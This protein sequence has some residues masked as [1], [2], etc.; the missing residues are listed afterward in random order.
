MA[1]ITRAP[2]H[3]DTPVAQA[4]LESPQQTNVITTYELHGD[5]ITRETRRNTVSF[6]ARVTNVQRPID[7]N[8]HGFHALSLPWLACT[9]AIRTARA[10]SGPPLP[11]RRQRSQP[12]A[13]R[14]QSTTGHRWRSRR[15]SC[16]CCSGRGWCRWSSACPGRRAWWWSI[17]RCRCSAGCCR[18]SCRS[19]SGSPPSPCAPSP[20]SWTLHQH[21][22]FPST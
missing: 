19:W 7:K 16:R 18:C 17:P 13:K 15:A 12:P 4:N 22:C 20:G 11:R 8:L 10:W 2:R 6:I 5:Q 21:M 3:D 14:R 1:C 9:A